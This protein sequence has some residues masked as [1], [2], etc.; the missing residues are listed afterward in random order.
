MRRFMPLAGGV[1]FVGLL[2]L[3]VPSAQGA[4]VTELDPGFA[5]QGVAFMTFPGAAQAIGNDLAVQSDGN[6]VT[7]G[8]EGGSSGWNFWAA[9]LS[10]G[11]S[12]DPSFGAGGLTT[13]APGSGSTS[14]ANSVA[15]APDGKLVLA[16]YSATSSGS[17][18]AVVRLNPSGSPD[19]T[20]NGDG[21]LTLDLGG[22]SD[23]LVQ[24]DG[25]IVLSAGTGNFMSP[26]SV[27]VRLN[28]DGSLDSSFNG[29][30]K[31]SVPFPVANISL[32]PGGKIVAAGEA[33]GPAQYGYFAV[34]R[35]NPNG[36]LDSGFGEGGVALTPSAPGYPSGLVVQGDG[37]IVLGGGSFILARYNADGSPDTSFGGGG[38]A[39][40]NAPNSLALSDLAET[41]DGGFVASA[42]GPEICF[43]PNP[44]AVSSSFAAA[45]F[46]SQGSLDPSFGNGGVYQ[47][48]KGGGYD[49]TRAVALQGNGVLLAG[50]S[51]SGAAAILRVI[52]GSPTIQPRNVFSFR[53]VRRNRRTGSAK[54]FV[55]VPGS[56]KLVLVGRGLKRVERHAPGAATAVLSVKA[57]GKA[58]RVLDQRGK[59]KV[60]ANVTYTPTGGAPRTR[61]K[62]ITLIKT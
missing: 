53:R 59:L 17:N 15:I 19:S 9:R 48:N 23:V 31:Q 4:V 56:G 25:R 49:F 11:G 50:D 18:V 57:K 47:V 3:A 26:S 32:Y 30:G 10:P 36:S 55:T 52:T 7:V 22:A 60:K 44:C 2:A 37:R 42:D 45:R 38:I 41:T 62:R 46:T 5:N 43:G 21:K 35:L 8:G 58:A 1:A 24:P 12:L 61:A 34:A 20:F 33:G 14:E 16:G 13:I 40:S 28:P 39:K 29:T 51:T 54:L 27:V 6:L